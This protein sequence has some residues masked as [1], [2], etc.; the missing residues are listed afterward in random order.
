MAL[1]TFMDTPCVFAIE[2]HMV[3]YTMPCEVSPANVL[4]INVGLTESQQEQLIKVLKIQSGA[5]AWEYTDMKGIHIETC[6]YHIY[7]DA[8]I[9]PIR[10]PQSRMNPALKDI[11]KEELQ[12]LLNVGFIY[13]IFDSKRVSPLVV[14]PNKFIGKWCIF[15]DFRELNKATLKD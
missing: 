4:Q 9:S 6:I 8:S 1:S 3:S 13:P 12:K 14:V 2:E 5:F 15:V 7:M 11:V 10:K